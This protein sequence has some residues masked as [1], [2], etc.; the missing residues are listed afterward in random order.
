MFILSS[1]ENV[2]PDPLENTIISSPLVN[3]VVVFGHGKNQAGVLIE[4]Q[5]GVD[6]SDVTAFRNLVWSVIV[7]RM[8]TMLESQLN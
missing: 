6:G 3:G 7:D 1:G 4:P 2:V 5:P 8:F